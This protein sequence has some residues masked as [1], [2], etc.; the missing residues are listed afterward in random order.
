MIEILKMYLSSLN[1]QVKFSLKLQSFKVCFFKILNKS[2]YII[3]L[4]LFISPHRSIEN[5]IDNF[6]L[7]TH[8]SKEHSFFFYQIDPLDH[9]NRQISKESWG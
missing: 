8:S 1:Q 5:V 6:I 7:V 4:V 2:Y 3:E 9:T